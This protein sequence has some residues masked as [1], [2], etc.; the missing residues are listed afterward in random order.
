L[1]SAA[2]RLTAR[3]LALP[4]K[5][6]NFETNYKKVRDQMWGYEGQLFKW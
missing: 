3:D 5:L 4:V 1:L 2:G 6:Y